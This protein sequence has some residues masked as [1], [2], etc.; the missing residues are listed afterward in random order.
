MKFEIHQNADTE[1]TTKIRFEK[2]C[3]SHSHKPKII[4]I[5]SVVIEESQN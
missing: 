1:K 4:E 2:T 3:F 5:G